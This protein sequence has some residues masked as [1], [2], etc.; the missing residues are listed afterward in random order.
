MG[1]ETGFLL[2]LGVCQLA[3]YPLDAAIAKRA[4]VW[5]PR[6]DLPVIVA[7]SLLA[8]VALWGSQQVAP[9]AAGAGAS[10]RDA[11]AR[12]RA[13][14]PPRSRPRRPGTGRTR[15]VEEPTPP[16]R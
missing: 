1:G 11:V 4:G 16:R 3:A 15:G 8:V 2:G 6:F 12:W 9:T 13:P 14:T 7:S 5:Q 10:V